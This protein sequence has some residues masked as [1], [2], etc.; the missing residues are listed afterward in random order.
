MEVR[1]GD[2]SAVEGAVESAVEDA[3]L[4]H[5]LVRSSAP[6]GRSTPDEATVEPERGGATAESERGGATAESERGGEPAESERD[7]DRERDGTESQSQSKLVA[8]ETREQSTLDA[9]AGA[10][11]RVPSNGDFGGPTGDPAV[12]DAGS[13][14]T[15]TDETTTDGT[16]TDATRTTD[17]A[18]ETTATTETAGSADTA[19]TTTAAPDDAPEATASDTAESPEVTT[20]TPDSTDL[21]RKFTAPT[22]TETLSGDSVADPEFETLPQMRVLGQL[23]DTYVVAETPDGLVLVDQHAADERIN[24]ERLREAFADDATS[25][26]LATPVELELTAGEA[27][28]FDDHREALGRLGF[29]AER[30]DRDGG[31]TGEDAATDRRVVVRTVPT[32]L[33]A[34]LDPERLRDALA[35]FVS[36][37]PGDR[38]DTVEAVADDLLADLA[39]YPSITGNTSLREGSVVE[40]LSA[41]DDCENPY[42]CPHGRPV[43]IEFGEEEIEDRFERDYPGHAGRRKE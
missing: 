24:Y 2:E 9:S 34:T 30:T 25:Q 20:E 31:P 39:C 6:R 35:E 16:N 18:T 33:D 17:E 42:A 4:D 36:T 19:E 26:M 8:S 22:E 15:S 5:G 37:D 40:L 29:R 7:A 32:V 12:E 21:D 11:G 28:V 23:H 41:L 13:T 27:A 1:W 38:G 3:L 10:S 14:G 43:I